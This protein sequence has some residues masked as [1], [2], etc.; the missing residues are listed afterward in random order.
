MTGCH[1]IA[2]EVI[3][4]VT[5]KLRRADWAKRSGMLYV[6]PYK[7][8]WLL[9]PEYAKWEV[10]GSISISIDKKKVCKKSMSLVV[11]TLQNS[12]PTL[13]PNLQFPG[14]N[15]VLDL[16]ISD[17]TRNGHTAI[18]GVSGCVS[19]LGAQ[20]PVAYLHSSSSN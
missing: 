11:S 20:N 2:T 14:N 8:L 18:L 10:L 4:A 13:S 15:R 3:P 17:G 16:L 5:P 19:I 7:G 12:H 1:H 9:I 6:H